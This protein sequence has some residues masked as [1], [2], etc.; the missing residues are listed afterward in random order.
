VA[1]DL[2]LLELDL[3][4][5]PHT[6][7]FFRNGQQILQFFTGVPQSVKFVVCSVSHRSCIIGLFVRSVFNSPS[8]RR[9]HNQLLPADSC[10]A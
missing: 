6:L 3:E 1:G 10:I 4:S 7:H 2:L 8:E 9:L 5:T